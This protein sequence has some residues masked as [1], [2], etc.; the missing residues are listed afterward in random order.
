MLRDLAIRL[1]DQD[2]R[3]R[4]WDVLARLEETNPALADT[5][6]ARM[7]TRARRG[8]V[9]AAEASF[10]VRVDEGVD[11]FLRFYEQVLT[12]R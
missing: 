11:A 12:A 3:G 5:I 4:A 8:Q 10:F 2:R 9:S 7:S 6:A 1:T